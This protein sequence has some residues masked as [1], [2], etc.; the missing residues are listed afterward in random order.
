MLTEQQQSKQTPV[1]TVQAR[2]EIKK[3]ATKRKS[4]FL[5]QITVF[6]AV[7]L[8]CVLMLIVLLRFLPRKAEEIKNLRSLGLKAAIQTDVKKVE[9]EIAG[10]KLKTDKLKAFFPDE[11]GL[12]DFVKEIDKLKKEGVVTHF[13][14]VS[15]SVVLDKTKLEGL[16]MVIEFRGNLSQVDQALQKLQE[17]PFLIRAINVQIK[18]EADKDSFDLKYGGILYVS[19][20]FAKN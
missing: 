3:K 14:F 9:A 6:G 15:N 19:E 20:T 12:I 18:K 5:M 11:N 17:A 8:I 10:S 16:P 2:P 1:K 13:S 4:G 7:D